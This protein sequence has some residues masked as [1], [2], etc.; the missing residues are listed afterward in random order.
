[1]NHELNETFS[2]TGRVAVITGAASGIGRETAN[3]LAQAGASVVLGDIQE[4]E[5]VETASLAN[6]AGAQAIVCRTDVSHRANIDALAAT[7]L[8]TFS[9]IDIWVNCAGIMVKTPLLDADEETLERGIAVNLKSVYW[10]CVAA[11]RA[12]KENGRGSIINISSGG[13]ESAVPEMSI[14][15]LTKAAGNMGTRSAAKELGP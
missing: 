15:C 2:L 10:G 5:L 11:G 12:M 3:V 6:A 7:A 14:Y 4:A 1:M 13:G 8:Q 9:R